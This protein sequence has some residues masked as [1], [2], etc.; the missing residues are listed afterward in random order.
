MTKRNGR[1][2]HKEFALGVRNAV[3]GRSSDCYKCLV[4]ASSR[5]KDGAN[6]FH[7]LP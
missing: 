7:I 6:M 4:V 1:D 2:V 5:S 3:R